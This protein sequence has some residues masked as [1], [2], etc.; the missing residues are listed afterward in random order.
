MSCEQFP[1]NIIKNPS[2]QGSGGGGGR[3]LWK[4]QVKI[5]TTNA[6][7]PG[8]DY[9]SESS[10]DLSKDLSANA[11]CFSTFDKLL[12]MKK[13][14]NIAPPPPQ[15]LK[16]QG[17]KLPARAWKGNQMAEA[18]L[19]SRGT[20]APLL[21]TMISFPQWCGASIMSGNSNQC[22]H[23]EVASGTLTLNVCGKPPRERTTVRPQ[24]SR[25]CL[26]RSLH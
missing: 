4:I 21:R 7:D 15:N 24:R 23:L 10:H 19:V 1:P 20:P 9:V 11:N 5:K 16:R 13:F 2:F 22:G 3:R 17:V 25:R 12:H 26:T 6:V 14:M 18:A 8:S